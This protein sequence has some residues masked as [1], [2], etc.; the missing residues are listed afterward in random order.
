MNID[1]Q[2]LRQ[3]ITQ[4]DPTIEWTDTEIDVISSYLLSIARNS[5]GRIFEDTE[6]IEMGVIEEYI[7]YAIQRGINKVMRLY[8]DSIS[9]STGSFYLVQDEDVSSSFDFLSPRKYVRKIDL[10]TADVSDLEPL[11][12]IG[13]VTAQSIVNYRKEHGPFIAIEEVIK[14]KG[15]DKNDFEKFW[16]AVYVSSPIEEAS[17]VSSP[18]LEFK[19]NPTFRSYLKLVKCGD[20]RFMIWQGERIKERDYKGSILNELRKI[21]EY[22]NNNPSPLRG[23]MRGAD[24]I[25]H[26]ALV[27]RDQIS[28]IMAQSSKDIQGVAVLDDTE[29]YYFLREVFKRARERIWVI[30]FFMRFEDE[31][32]YPTDLLIDELL[33]AKSRGV[34]IRIILD[35]DAEGD[36][37]GSRVINEE[38]YNFFVNNGIEVTWDSEEIVTHT[39]MVLIDDKHLIVGS[40]NWTAGSFFVYD[41]KSVY[42]ESRN[43]AQKASDD[44]KR[45]WLEYTVTPSSYRIIDIE[46]IGKTYADKLQQV[47]VRST[48]DLLFKAVTPEDRKRL[49]RSAKISPK[50]ILRWTN[51]ADL[52]RLKGIGREYSELLEKVG[53]DTV[54]ELAQRNSKHLHKVIEEF[55]ISKTRLVRRK[56]SCGEIESWV[57]QAKTSMRILTY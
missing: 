5:A 10:N 51:L 25:Q 43:L 15:I 45:L 48:S 23:K 32:T 47:G 40:H 54:P 34:E 38:V 27:L 52:M 8:A 6:F 35:R 3:F 33:L 41:D 2:K 11:L 17:Y 7:L 24:E 42:V 49:A 57:E 20:G 1:R 28:R 16:F 46:G 9:P 29:Y 39:K 26:S 50:R 55:D 31:E 37:Y 22:L 18:L 19:S 4:W 13:P 12:G 56:P 30:M 44:F 21:D 53:V 36:V 14:V